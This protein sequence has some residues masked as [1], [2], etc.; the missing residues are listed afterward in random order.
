M[1]MKVDLDILVDVIEE[2]A[3]DCAASGTTEQLLLSGILDEIAA[4]LRTYH[5]QNKDN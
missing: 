2:V 1:K 5:A 4:K 3:G